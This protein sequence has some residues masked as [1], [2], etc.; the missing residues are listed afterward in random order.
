M[1]Q[2]TLLFDRETKGPLYARAGLPEYWIVNLVDGALEVYRDPRVAPGSAGGWRYATRLVLDRAGVAVPLAAPPRV[3]AWRICSPD[4]EPTALARG[5][6]PR[7]WS[8]A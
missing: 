1:A 5:A 2:S 7:S 8:R 6:P 3:S 4:P